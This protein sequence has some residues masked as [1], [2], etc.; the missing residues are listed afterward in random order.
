LVGASSL[1][2]MHRSY[3]QQITRHTGLNYTDHDS[4]CG[5]TA[6]M[7]L[8]GWNDLNWTPTLLEGNPRHNR[9]SPAIDQLTM[10]LHHFLGTSDPPY[11]WWNDDQG[12]TAPDTMMDGVL[13]IERRLGHS[14]RY[15]CRAS[16]PS[17]DVDWLFEVARSVARAGR[18]FIVGYW[19]DWH[20]A[21]GYEIAECANH[22]WE[23]HSWIRVFPA[24]SEN[25]NDDKWVSKGDIFGVYGVYE[26]TQLQYLVTVRT[27]NFVGAG[28]D[29][30]V[31]VTLFGSSS[32]SDET[33]LDAPGRNDFEQGATDNFGILATDIGE[34]SQVRIRHDDSGN[35]PGWFLE[36]I[37]VRNVYS[38]IEWARPRRPAAGPESG[39][40]ESAPGFTS[41]RETRLPQSGTRGYVLNPC[42]RT[43]A[44]SARWPCSSPWSAAGLACRCS[45]RWCFTLP[46]APRRRSGPWPLPDQPQA[47]RRCASWAGWPP[48][49][50]ASLRFR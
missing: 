44:E 13:F 2:D 34:I 20:Y 9:D 48:T 17:S 26:F 43:C 37:R 6:W 25:D 39:A 50:A 33:L 30:N 35:H 40:P 3:F 7:N 38:G 31:Y 22:G 28:T 8:I 32:A 41:Q 23:T 19:E 15:W 5:P 14:T 29:A 16:W 21:L 47:T 4:G 24:W 45:M 10:G 18:P 49:A 36:D 46:G 11:I 12:Y 27:G 42:G 1:D